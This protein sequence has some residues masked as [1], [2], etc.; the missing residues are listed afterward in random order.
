MNRYGFFFLRYRLAF[1]RGPARFAHR[2]L[3]RFRRGLYRCHR[4]WGRLHLAARLP[5]RRRSHSRRPCHQQAQFVHGNVRGDA[6]LRKV[7][8]RGSAS[9]VACRRVRVSGIMRRFVGGPTCERRHSARSASRHP[10]DYSDLRAPSRSK[11]PPHV[12]CRF[13]RPFFGAAVSRLSWGSTMGS[14]VLAPV[15]FSCWP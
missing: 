7:G 5:H 13:A 12:A 8:I 9:S 10:S 6:P 2:V 1:R 3:V 4:G 14:T 15:R 11:P